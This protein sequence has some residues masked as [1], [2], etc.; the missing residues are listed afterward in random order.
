MRTELTI[1]PPNSLLVVADPASR[2]VPSRLSLPVAASR[3]CL[4]IGTTAGRIESV[5][6]VL[7]DEPDID[8]LHL[9][10]KYHGT[11]D[12]PSSTLSVCS[13]SLERYLVLRT[14]TDQANVQVWTND[15]NE[16][17]EVLVRVMPSA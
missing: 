1:A 16:P 6:V 3:T 10:L 9:S 12:L 17:T 11:L 7:T 8:T 15:D 13:V 5:H 2:G 14:P 4:M